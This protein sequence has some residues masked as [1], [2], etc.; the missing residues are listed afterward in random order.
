MPA[1]CSSIQEVS[2]R[3]ATTTGAMVT[4]CGLFSNRLHPFWRESPHP[5]APKRVVGFLVKNGRN[6]CSYIKPHRTYMSHAALHRL[7]KSISQLPM[8]NTDKVFRSVNAMLGVMCHYDAFKLRKL[9]FDT[10][11]FRRIGFFDT[12]M[13]TFTLWK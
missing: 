6:G 10:E 8:K 11:E 4:R 3:R 13:T 5:D 7:R 9:L 12:N 2:I 1:A